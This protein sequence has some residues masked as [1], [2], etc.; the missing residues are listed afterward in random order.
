MAR[1]ESQQAQEGDWRRAYRE[2]RFG[3]LLV[4]LAALLAG[5][6]VLLGFG[7]SAAWFDGLMALLLVAAIV[8][9]CF[10]R[11]QR[12][13]ALLLGIPTVLLSVGGHALPG[14]ASAPVLLVRHLCEVLFL[15]GASVLIVKS[16]FS[17]P[18]LTFDSILGA[19]CGYL[20]LGLAWAVR[21]ARIA[22]F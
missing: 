2:R 8:A 11:P 14:E 13:F 15:F 12:L 16:L 6:P 10:E 5:P 20:F 18:T 22:G 9:L 19:V 1:G 4:I 21:Y 7:L 3:V 17:A